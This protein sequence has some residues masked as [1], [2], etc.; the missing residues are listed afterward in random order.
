MSTVWQKYLDHTTIHGFR[1]LSKEEGTLE[2][3]AWIP[4]LVFMI[5]SSFYLI[6]DSFESYKDNPKVTFVEVVDVN[7]V[8]FPDITVCSKYVQYS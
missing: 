4:I 8:P 3:I 7:Q 6:N 5:A 1:Y 2:R